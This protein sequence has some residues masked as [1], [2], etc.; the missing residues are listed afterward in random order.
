M[1]LPSATYDVVLVHGDTTTSTV[2]ALAT[3]YQQI[4][5]SHVLAGLRTHNI[6]NPCPEEM[7]RQITGHIA[8]YNFAPTPISEKNLLVKIVQ[9]QIL[10]SGNTVIDA[11]HMMVDKLRIDKDL[12]YKQVN[13]LKN[14]WYDITRLN[15]GKKLVLINGHRRENF[16]DCFISM[17]TVMKY[18]SEKY[19]E[20][21]LV[22][23]MHLNPNVRKPIH[24]VFGED[25][26]P[27]RIFFFS[28]YNT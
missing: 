28:R 21:D 15:C 1:C 2:A 8:T 12:A 23:P 22:Y 4:P 14:A 18:L 20:V 17:V 26:P 7:I 13:V 10:V 24:K 25:L 19:P 3:F 9:G 11:L 27:I 6:Y 16:G 5:E